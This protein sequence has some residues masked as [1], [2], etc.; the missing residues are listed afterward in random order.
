MSL[1]E[2]RAELGAALREPDRTG[3]ADDGRT[4]HYQWVLSSEPTTVSGHAGVDELLAELR[5]SYKV[6]GIEALLHNR[7]Q[8]RF[9]VPCSH[10]QGAGCPRCEGRG[11]F[12]MRQETIR[13]LSNGGVRIAG[14]ELR[15]FSA[16]RFEAFAASALAATRERYTAGLADTVRYFDQEGPS[17]A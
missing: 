12:H 4:I 2:L 1:T 15:R 5:V 8:A 3:R 6:G 14:E 11:F 9:E 17:D 13:L 7:E 10:C 16:K